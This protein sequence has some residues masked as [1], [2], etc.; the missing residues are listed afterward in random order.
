M[1]FLFNSG[2]SSAMAN[3]GARTTERVNKIWLSEIYYTA[4]ARCKL[5]IALFGELDKINDKATQK[6]KYIV[7]TEVKIFSDLHKSL[8]IPADTISETAD[9]FLVKNKYIL[10][11]NPYLDSEEINPTNDLKSR[12][13]ILRPQP[14]EVP[15]N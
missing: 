1:F 13:W 2:L 8:A 12:R 7:C 6:C 5:D 3:C 4:Q 11:N 15:P 14:V 10:D 9:S